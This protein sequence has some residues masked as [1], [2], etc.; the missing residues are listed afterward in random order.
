MVEI[1]VDMKNLL[2]PATSSEDLDEGIGE[3]NE[4]EMFR[5]FPLKTNR[6]MAML[7]EEEEEEGPIDLEALKADIRL[8]AVR[9]TKKP[10]GLRPGKRPK[11]MIGPPGAKQDTSRTDFFS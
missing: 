9:P 3:E 4:F 6:R 11:K 8:K 7:R 2:S 10:T 1:L 5:K